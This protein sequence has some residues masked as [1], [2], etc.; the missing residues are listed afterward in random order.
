[1]SYHN[2]TIL[3]KLHTIYKTFFRSIENSPRGLQE[4]NDLY[5]LALALT[6][7]NYRMD[8]SDSSL[9][10][11][12]TTNA[13]STR[14]TSNTSSTNHHKWSNYK[15]ITTNNNNNLEEL[16]DKTHDIL[17][18]EQKIYN[19]SIRGLRSTIQE[20]I[21]PQLFSLF[22][23]FQYVQDIIPSTTKL[24]IIIDDDDNNN[25]N[26]G[27]DSTSK[28][29]IEMK[30]RN[31]IQ[32]SKLLYDEQCQTLEWLEEYNNMNSTMNHNGNDIYSRDDVHDDDDNNN[33]RNSKQLLFL[34]K[35]LSAIQTIA[36]YYQWE[37]FYFDNSLDTTI[38]HEEMKKDK[39]DEFGY[40]QSKDE[41]VN[42]SIRYYQMINLSRSALI[43]QQ[44]GYSVLSLKSTIPNAGR[45]IFVDGFAPAG[46]LLAFFPGDVWPKEHLLNSNALTKYFQ[47]D[48]RH[49]LSMRYDDILIDSRKSPYTVLDDVN[50]N[51]FAVAHIVNHPSE[52][53]EPNC[54]TLA[55]DFIDDMKLDE[56]DLLQF[57]PNQYKKKP[58]M[59]GPQAVDTDSIRVHS[60]GLVAL[61]D[62]KNQELFYDY[63]LSPGTH[64]AL[65]EWY[66]VFD[67]EAVRNRWHN[68]SSD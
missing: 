62:I 68:D 53:D 15:K 4:K 65:P 39:S 61:H 18:Q 22:Y 59:F 36:S 44:I 52:L 64:K 1:M 58:M 13:S 16:Y 26:D 23:L 12:T 27:F 50:S 32:C 19:L 43:R 35:K 45:G 14:S 40:I 31:I 63:R 29:I 30:E 33:N 66:H 54:S 24:G 7:R 55:I 48:P 41:Q 11:A 38:Q 42:N 20:L 3:S 34:N 6:F 8:H 28:H 25:M 10:S 21:R 9:S 60:M 57:V 17:F 67:E 56:L 37:N 2:K 46:S 5:T 49:L 51:A 47:Q